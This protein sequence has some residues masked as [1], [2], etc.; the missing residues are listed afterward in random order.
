MVL[1]GKTGSGKSATGKTISG[2]TQF[3]SIPSS[4]SVTNCC[5]VRNGKL[6]ERR[7]VIVDTPGVFHTNDTTEISMNEI[8]RCIKMSSPGPHVFLLVIKADRFTEE[9]NR[10]INILLELLSDDIFAFTVVIFTRLDDIEAEGI[11]I[12]KFVKSSTEALNRL[13]KRVNFRYIAVNNRGT[14]TQ[15]M[16]FILSLK[17]IINKMQQENGEQYYTIGMYKEAVSKRQAKILTEESTNVLE[18]L[19]IAENVETKFEN[20]IN[21]AEWTKGRLQDELSKQKEQSTRIKTECKKSRQVIL[22]MLLDLTR[23]K[24]CH[25]NDLYNTTKEEQQKLEYRLNDRSKQQNKSI[26]L[27]AASS[28][29]NNDEIQLQNFEHETMVHL[30]NQKIQFQRQM[31][32]AINMVTQTSDEGISEIKSKL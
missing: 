13:T 10:S 22:G 8:V 25:R 21:N 30:R 11:S 9:E 28:C 32:G 27:Y 14:T 29:L 24:A 23:T 20:V 16:S 5:A 4:S 2:K 6:E 3:E 15:Q 1:L 19:K 18:K 26:S 12:D 31:K 7:L 17:T